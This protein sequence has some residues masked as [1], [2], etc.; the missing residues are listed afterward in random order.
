MEGWTAA[1]HAAGLR[2]RDGA[3]DGTAPSTTVAYLF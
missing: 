3:S 2:P 1:N